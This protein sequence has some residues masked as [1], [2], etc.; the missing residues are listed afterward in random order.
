[1]S[2]ART[3]ADRMTRFGGGNVLPLAA[4]YDANGQG[5]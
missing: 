2:A 4:F 1:M 3:A 5:P